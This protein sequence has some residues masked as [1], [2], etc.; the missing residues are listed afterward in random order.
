MGAVLN[1]ASSRALETGSGRK[2]RDCVLRKYACVYKSK[3]E[4]ERSTHKQFW[5]RWQ[6]ESSVYLK[7]NSHSLS[8]GFFSVFLGILIAFVH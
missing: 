4:F 3:C 6:F 7:E 2:V 1:A 5:L 8:Q